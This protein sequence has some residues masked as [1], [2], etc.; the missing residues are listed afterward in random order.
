MPHF[1]T[2]KKTD[3]DGFTEALKHLIIIQ[4]ATSKVSVSTWRGSRQ[5]QNTAWKNMPIYQKRRNGNNSTVTIP[6]NNQ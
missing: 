3:W 5:L 1:L 6:W 2:N 4:I